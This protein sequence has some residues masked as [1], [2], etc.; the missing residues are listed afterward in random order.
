MSYENGDSPGLAARKAQLAAALRELAEARQQTDVQGPQ[1]T[2]FA[3]Q[4]VAAAQKAVKRQQNVAS[5]KPAL[6]D[7]Q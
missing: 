5:G 3:R 6:D 2:V 7:D 1:G 4:Q